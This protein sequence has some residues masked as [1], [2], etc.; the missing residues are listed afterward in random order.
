[1][2]LCLLFSEELDNL[3]VGGGDGSDRTLSRGPQVVGD[4][5]VAKHI[6]TGE[7]GRGKERERKEEE[8]RE[9]ETPN[10]ETLHTWETRKAPLCTH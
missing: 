10:K 9:R 7:G 4:A 1:M 6:P 3:L 5:V 2:W 8:G